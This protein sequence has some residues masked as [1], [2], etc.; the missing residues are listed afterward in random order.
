MNVVTF[1]DRL[2]EMVSK[3]KKAEAILG[4]LF[5]KWETS[6]L[7]LYDQPDNEAETTAIIN[8]DRHK[9]DFMV[10]TPFPVFRLAI[11]VGEHNQPAWGRYRANALVGNFEDGLA[12]LAS[13]E[14]LL[15]TKRTW[16]LKQKGKNFFNNREDKLTLPIW[17]FLHKIRLAANARHDK[18]DFEVSPE[19]L[20]GLARKWIDF[21]EEKRHFAHDPVRMQLLWEMASNYFNGLIKSVVAFNIS[22][23]APNNHIATVAPAQPHRSVQ[24]VQ[25]RTHYTLISHGH[26]A[27]NRNVQQG[28]RVAVD[29]EAELQRMAHNRRA[30]QRTLRSERFRYARGKTIW[31][32]ATWVGAKEWQDAGGKQ[33][34]K[35]LEP[36]DI[37]T[38]LA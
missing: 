38:S 23:N 29:Q 16:E 11:S 37:Q 12:V 14:S 6:P 9:P 8:A 20:F 35:I 22:A 3:S 24:W 5:P 10:H 2:L 34:Y 4:K 13:I 30:H 27:N 1:N 25:A 28:S 33:I 17:M 26:P 18:A 31:V 7:F 36:V 15:H 21:D 32:K 19:A